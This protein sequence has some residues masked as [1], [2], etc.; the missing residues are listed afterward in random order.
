M[1][2]VSI[3]HTRYE[4]PNKNE[5]HVSKQHITGHESGKDKVVAGA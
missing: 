5:V 1:N 2:N 4:F 3:I